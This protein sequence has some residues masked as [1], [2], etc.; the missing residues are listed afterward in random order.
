M[1][2]ETIA[3]SLA[4]I[5]NRKMDLPQMESIREFQFDCDRD[6]YLDIADA[7]IAIVL[8]AAARVAENEGADKATAAS[9]GGLT[10]FGEGWDAASARIATAIREMGG[11]RG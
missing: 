10:D 1:L 4:N 7:I 8:E 3:L 9:H 6:V 2:R 5:D 11:E